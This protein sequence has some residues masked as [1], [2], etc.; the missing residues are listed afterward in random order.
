MD[1]TL[2]VP[3]STQTY[4][5]TNY[6]GPGS[7]V[8]P[9]ANTD[10]GSCTY[11]CPIVNINSIS[12]AGY[13]TLEFNTSNTIYSSLFVDS[14]TSP[15]ATTSLVVLDALGNSIYS[16]TNGLGGWTNAAS[17]N[18][19]DKNQYIGTALANH[20]PA[21]SNGDIINVTFG[22]DTTD[23]ECSVQTQEAYSIGCTDNAANNSGSWDI[24]Y[25]SICTYTGCMDDTLDNNGNYAAVGAFPYSTNNTTPC[26]T[27]GAPGDAGYDPAFDNDCCTYNTN[28]TAQLLYSGSSSSGIDYSL[29]HTL[30]FNFN[31]TAYQTATI[32]AI[33]VETTG[34]SYTTWNSY[35]IGGASSYGGTASDSYI[36]YFGGNSNLTLGT[37]GVYNKDLQPLNFDNLD[38]A[39]FA[40][41]EHPTVNTL[42]HSVATGSVDLEIQYTIQWT[43]PISNTSLG[44][45]LTT[46]TTHTQTFTGGCRVGS[47]T[48]Y[49]NYD[50]TLQLQ[51]P[52]SCIPLVGGCTDPSAFNYCSSCNAD[53]SNNVGGTDMG[54]CQ[55]I[56]NGCTDST[57]FNYNPAANTDDGSCCLPPCAVPG[58]LSSSF[59]GT[60][61]VLLGYTDI[62][63]ADY[64]A[65]E[66]SIDGGVNWVISGYSTSVNQNAPGSFALDIS[67]F[68]SGDELQIRMNS[69][70]VYDVTGAG[71]NSTYTNIITYMVP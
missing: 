15:N 20:T 27:T 5:A 50:P 42:A 52:N 24:S 9:E 14:G 62:A 66:T 21:F 40:G 37:G 38:T 49:I 48:Q 63:C 2:S 43:G 44:G 34:Q 32:T 22:L 16:D 69:V 25:N 55:A 51:I 18:A 68:T 56:V 6:A 29:F 28:P 58:T 60:G 70:C 8:T 67:S 17:F 61:F 11:N 71:A 59:G 12:G 57:A 35:Y 30:E 36:T 65:V 19:M 41:L 45:Q 54:C 10:D 1:A 39:T 64:Y 23:G 31:A 13:I 53:C 26:N 33:S 3:N 7:G 46:T 47:A 4:A